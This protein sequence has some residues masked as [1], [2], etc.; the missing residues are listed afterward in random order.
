MSRHSWPISLQTPLLNTDRQTHCSDD[1]GS[2]GFMGLQANFE[3][4]IVPILCGSF[5]QVVTGI[6]LKFQFHRLWVYKNKLTHSSVLIHTG[7]CGKD[8]RMDF[9]SRRTLSLRKPRPFNTTRSP[10]PV[11]GEVGR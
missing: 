11:G 1:S 8:H 6:K 2:S 4:E 10:A 3:V 7:Y 9:I 5:A